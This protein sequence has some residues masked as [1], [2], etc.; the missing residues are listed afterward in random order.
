[1]A[2]FIGARVEEL[3]FETLGSKVDQDDGNTVVEVSQRQWELR[4]AGVGS[5]DGVQVITRDG[6]KTLGDVCR[7]VMGNVATGR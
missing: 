3:T 5:L 6:D 2:D 1:M 7:R 4:L